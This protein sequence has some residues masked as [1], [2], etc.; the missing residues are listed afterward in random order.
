MKSSNANENRTKSLFIIY[1]KN[2]DIVNRECTVFRQRSAPY[3]FRT[4]PPLLTGG[5]EEGEI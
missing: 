2:L 1:E 3:F 4:T 5:D